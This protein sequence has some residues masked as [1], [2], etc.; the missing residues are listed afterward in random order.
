MRQMEKLKQEM[1]KQHSEEK[2]KDAE[3]K[4]KQLE[5][6]LEEMR[7]REER[8]LEELKESQKKNEEELKRLQEEQITGVL[9][10]EKMKRLQAAQ[11][12]LGDGEAQKS[13][14]SALASV[15]SR[16]IS[17]QPSFAAFSKAVRKAALCGTSCRR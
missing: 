2:Q 8:R 4:Q 17:A 7:K 9:E 14:P 15:A 16:P 5:G 12:A 11:E 6:K 13:Q 3:E 1:E 10:S